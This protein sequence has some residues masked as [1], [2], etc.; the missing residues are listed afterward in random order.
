MSRTDQ[1]DTL[2]YLS[3]VAKCCKSRGGGP[4][5]I[6]VTGMW[7]NQCFWAD[8]QSRFCVGEQ[9]YNLPPQPIRLGRI[10]AG[11]DRRPPGSH[12]SGPACTLSGLQLVTMSNPGEVKLGVA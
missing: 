6:N 8:F 12:D 10:K 4:A 7:R 9:L 5:G 11:G 1:H 3:A 2:Q